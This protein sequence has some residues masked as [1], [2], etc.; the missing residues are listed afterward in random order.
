MLE[1]SWLF[2]PMCQHTNFNLNVKHYFS[3]ARIEK[4]LKSKRL[5]WT[6]LVLFE[7]VGVINPECCQRQFTAFLFVPVNKHLITSQLKKQQKAKQNAILPPTSR[8]R[9]FYS[10]HNGQ[11]AQSSD[12]ILGGRHTDIVPTQYP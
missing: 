10:P 8:G 6:L 11:D 1:Q 7:E 3:Y 12:C 2:Y 5:L 4:F 9:G